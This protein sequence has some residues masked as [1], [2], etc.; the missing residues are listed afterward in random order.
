MPS[1]VEPTANII[2]RYRTYT[3]DEDTTA[4]ALELLEDIAIKTFCMSYRP[5]HVLTLLIEHGIG[6][7]IVF[8]YDK[9]NIQS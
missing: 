9:I 2:E 4:S 3:Q 8:I 1:Y 7:I 6:E 5:I